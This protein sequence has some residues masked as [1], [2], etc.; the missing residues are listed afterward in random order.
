LSPPPARRNLSAVLGGVV[1][2]TDVQ[3]VELVELDVTVLDNAERVALGEELN[4]QAQPHASKMT[5][6]VGR[7]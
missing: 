7:R 5:P 1:I 3:S 4:V 6:G 2:D